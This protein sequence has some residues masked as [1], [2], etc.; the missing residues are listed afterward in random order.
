MKNIIPNASVRFETVNDL[1]DFVQ[2]RKFQDKAMTASDLFFR[3]G[4]INGNA[5]MQTG[6]E[7]LLYRLDI[8]KVF[9]EKIPQD[10]L[11][12]NINRLLKENGR[13]KYLVRFQDDKVRAVLSNS[14]QPIDDKK[15]VATLAERLDNTFGVTNVI[16]DDRFSRVTVTNKDKPFDVAVGDRW[17]GGVDFFNS[18]VGYHAFQ[19]MTYL[20]RLICLNGAIAKE[21]I[22]GERRV[23]RGNPILKY[24]T[25]IRAAIRN[26]GF[27]QREKI[28][29]LTKAAVDSSYL[30]R[31]ERFLVPVLGTESAQE[32][33]KQK[34]DKAKTRYDVINAV[35][36][37]AH[38][39]EKNQFAKQRE[40][41][42]VGGRL[43][44][45]A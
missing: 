28:M 5:V 4:Q 40:L 43:L 32:F 25:D 33:R 39:F 9:A 11:D 42:A 24:M 30:N 45:A 6:L 12:H 41:E 3:N 26:C 36:A 18:G 22:A 1:N 16:W 2:A 20:F 27:D 21:G 13:D 31:V 7:T 8:P 10:L 15:V 29:A 34:L 37:K 19:A 35:T 14:Y 23:H 17:I 44:M 38:D